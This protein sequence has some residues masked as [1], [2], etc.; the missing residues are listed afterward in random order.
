MTIRNNPIL[1]RIKRYSILPL[2][3][4][5]SMLPA[6][7]AVPLANAV[8]EGNAA[9][10][11]KQLAEGA[12]I[13]NPEAPPLIA[14]AE[15]NNTEMAKWLLNNGAT[16]DIHDPQTGN[17]AFI[18]AAGN[19]NLNL[20]NA[21][22]SRGATIEAR[23]NAGD[24]ALML[25]AANGQT[26]AVRFLLGKGANINSA[27]SEGWPPLFFAVR[28]GHTNMVKLLL[29]RGADVNARNTRGFTPLL[30][31]SAYGCTPIVTL[32]LDRGA[33]IDVIDTKW[34]Q[35]ALHWATVN[36][37]IDTAKVLLQ[38]GIDTTPRNYKKFTALQGAE[39]YERPEIKR[40]IETNSPVCRQQMLAGKAREYRKKTAQYLKSLPVDQL[41]RQNELENPLF[42]PIQTALLELARQIQLPTYLRK[43][44]ESLINDLLTV[45]DIQRSQA[46]ALIDKY[47]TDRYHN[48]SQAI[49]DLNFYMKELDSYRRMLDSAKENSRR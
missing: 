39:I 37:H 46:Q 31:A 32:L 11:S 19:G 36:N 4:G 5:L 27:N 28:H 12:D 25:A 23:N 38:R 41:L 6:G 34:K 22:I 40:L 20:M 44:D 17:T 47:K 35:T 15:A 9:E 26:D 45:V 21:L 18:I 7:C 42:V 14:A 29:D 48:Y 16:V 13:N 2:L 33:D 3:T 8:R 1:T 49:S 30:I 24:T 10:V 43:A